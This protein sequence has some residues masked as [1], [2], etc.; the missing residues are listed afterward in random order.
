MDQSSSKNDVKVTSYPIPY[1]PELMYSWKQRQTGSKGSFLTP[2]DGKY[3]DKA[4][5]TSYHGFV[6]DDHVEADRGVLENAFHGAL[7]GLY[8]RD[9]TQPFG[10]GSPC[11][12]TYVTRCLVGDKGSTYRYLGM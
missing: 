3:F 5:E 8:L 4:L 11:A 7:S 6:S 10:L 1:P 9:I 12:K 2:K